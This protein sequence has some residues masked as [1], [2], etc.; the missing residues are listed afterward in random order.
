MQAEYKELSERAMKLMI[1]FA[2]SYLYETVF[3]TC[4]NKEQM[5]ITN[6]CGMCNGSG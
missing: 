4:H 3:S 5:P 1:P 2:T 6:K